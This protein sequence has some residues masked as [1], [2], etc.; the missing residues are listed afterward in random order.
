MNKQKGFTLTEMIV[1]IVCLTV[2]LSI[3]IP[4]LQK[5]VT[6]AKDAKAIQ[7]MRVVSQAENTV[8]YSTKSFVTFEELVAKEYIQE[9]NFVNDG[10]GYEFDLSLNVDN[11]LFTAKPRYTNFIYPSGTMRLGVDNES[12]IYFERGNLGEFFADSN[13]MRNVGEP[14]ATTGE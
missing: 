3:A 11:Y 7:G 2:V 1:V 5:A 12:V 10:N 8:Y 13:E 14:L 6:R 9:E 4:L